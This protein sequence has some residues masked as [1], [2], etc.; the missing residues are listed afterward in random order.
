MLPT[1]SILHLFQLLIIPKREWHKENIFVL[2]VTSLVVVLFNEA[3]KAV[4][5]GDF[6]CLLGVTLDIGYCFALPLTSL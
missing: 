2:F 3:T 1:Q 5:V 6:V 4:K